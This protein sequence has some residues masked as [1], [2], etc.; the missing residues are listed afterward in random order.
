[1]RAI[2]ARDMSQ[3]TR[4]YQIKG[5]SLRRRKEDAISASFEP[6]PCVEISLR[7]QTSM[8][9]SD[10]LEYREQSTGTIEA[11]NSQRSTQ[12]KRDDGRSRSLRIHFRKAH[13]NWGGDQPGCVEGKVTS[14]ML[15]TPL[16]VAPT[17]DSL[18]C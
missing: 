17:S 7:K 14:A 15:M 6:R 13:P 5:E 8:R 9:P 16:A 10:A 4:P 11:I 12:K 1:M 18:T 3:L 2:R